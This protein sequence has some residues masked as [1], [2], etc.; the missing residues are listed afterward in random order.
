MK[1]K[2]NFL[3]NLLLLNFKIKIFYFESILINRV[4]LKKFRS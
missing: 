3:S 1:L 4:K 2:I